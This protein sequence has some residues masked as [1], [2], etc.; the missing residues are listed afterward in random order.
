MLL[1][2]ISLIHEQNTCVWR[3][4]CLFK[5]VTCE[6]TSEYSVGFGGGGGFLSF[7]QRAVRSTGGVGRGEGNVCF[8]GLDKTFGGLICLYLLKADVCFCCCR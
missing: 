5:V 7:C 4:K 2:Q 3:V 8:L 1:Q 6:R